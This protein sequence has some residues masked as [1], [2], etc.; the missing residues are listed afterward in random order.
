[1]LHVVH[2]AENYRL[3]LVRQE[4]GDVR[5]VLEIDGRT[6][7]VVPVDNLVKFSVRLDPEHA[8]LPEKQIRQLREELAI[9][10]GQLVDLE[11]LR[12]RLRVAEEAA[13]VAERDRRALIQE[14]QPD[15]P[16]VG[17]SDDPQT[18]Q[19]RLRPEQIELLL[20]VAERE[21]VESEALIR[22]I[23]AGW[24]DLWRRTHPCAETPDSD[25]LA[26]CPL[27]HPRG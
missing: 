24:L 26:N 12:E 23:V 27:L 3:K 2:E 7:A 20:H 13:E 5:L 19:V 6:K 17:V 18:V 22:M 15:R 25:H 1:M 14:Q 21:H 9:A 11:V 16:V 8:S 4:P 10:K